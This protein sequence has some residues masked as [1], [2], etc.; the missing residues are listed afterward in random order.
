MSINREE[1]LEI[2]TSDLKEI[3][4]KELSLTL[5]SRQYTIFKRM[6]ENEEREVR[7]VAEE[8]M[9]ASNGSLL[10]LQSSNPN[11][12]ND[13]SSSLAQ[14]GHMTDSSESSNNPH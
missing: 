12:S 7:A 2:I 5:D 1:L 6:V 13:T 3:Q 10:N 11:P 8:V 4:G 9:R 14:N